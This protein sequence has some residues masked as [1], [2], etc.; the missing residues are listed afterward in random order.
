M[1]MVQ[2]SGNFLKLQIGIVLIVSLFS[3]CNWL[4]F[5]DNNLSLSRESIS[6]LR[7]DGYYYHYDI[8]DDLFTV[9][10]LYENGII[11]HEGDKIDTSSQ[12]ILNL[13]NNKTNWG[14]VN[15]SANVIKFERWYPSSGGGLPA[16]VRERKILSDTSFHITRSYRQENGVEEEIRDKDE[17]N[18]FKEFSPK[19]D[20][21][22]MFIN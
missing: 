13:A 16:I 21:T 19:P 9:Y 17:I 8:Q 7:I 20:S 22:N 1:V 12:H 15:I 6:G 3:C 10:F 18:F 4:E 5:E 14:V 11:R 2:V